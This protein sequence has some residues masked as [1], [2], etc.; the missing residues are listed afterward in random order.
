M[1]PH[2][3]R[4]LRCSGQNWNFT[5]IKNITEESPKTAKVRQQ[6]KKKEKL[7]F[8]PAFRSFQTWCYNPV[9]T[10]WK[11]C[12]NFGQVLVKHN[13]VYSC[14]PLCRWLP[15][16]SR[17]FQSM[18]PKFQNV[19]LILLATCSKISPVFF[20]QFR[21]CLDSAHHSSP[22]RGSAFS[23]RFRTSSCCSWYTHK[24]PRKCC[25]ADVIID[26]SRASRDIRSIIP[27]CHAAA[28]TCRREPKHRPGQ[29]QSSPFGGTTL[30]I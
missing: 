12:V 1:M 22:W 11:A 17:W 3:S 4:S 5:R 19:F 6:M 30:W 25:R 23:H 18:L 10:N 9:T 26:K 8:L 29:A 13:Q 28:Q 24:Y 15:E 16:S 14:S 20:C 21:T 7:Y 2:V 27:V